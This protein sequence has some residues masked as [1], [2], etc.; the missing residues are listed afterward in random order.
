MGTRTCRY[1]YCVMSR[2]SLITSWNCR[3]R[4][5]GTRAQ[6]CPIWWGEWSGERSCKTSVTLKM[7]RHVHCII[8][9]THRLIRKENI[10]LLAC[11]KHFGL[12]TFFNCSNSCLILWNFFKLYN[13]NWKEENLSTKEGSQTEIV[14]NSSCL[15][16]MATRLP[17]NKWYSV[18]RSFF[19]GFLM[20]PTLPVK[21]S[22][23]Q[24]N[25]HGTVLWAFGFLYMLIQQSFATSV[26]TCDPGSMHTH[27]LLPSITDDLASW[28]A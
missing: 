6:Y 13:C 10:Q 5:R 9:Y 22:F 8:V 25:G 19:H 1:Q 23:R 20:Q 15:H 14:C 18:V 11:Y 27:D 2:G 3:A 12:W 28:I 26:R 24:Y 21:H 4:W 16:A 7:V 17:V